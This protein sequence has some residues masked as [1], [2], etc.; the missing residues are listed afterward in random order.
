MMSRIPLFMVVV[1][2]LVMLGGCSTLGKNEG[3]LLQTARFG[4]NFAGFGRGACRMG[5]DYFIEKNEDEM[6]NT[7]GHIVI[8]AEPNTVNP[9]ATDALA[10]EVVVRN[11]RPTEFDGIVIYEVA[12]TTINEDGTLKSY[13]E[14]RMLALTSN[15]DVRFLWQQSVVPQ[16]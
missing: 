1:L 3:V 16:G 11:I 13:Q 7:L 5:M 10:G 9:W 14:V 15:D 4:C 6:Y 8:T 12:Y 2:S